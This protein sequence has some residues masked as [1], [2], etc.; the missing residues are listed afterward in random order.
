[1]EE[2]YEN[3][4]IQIGSCLRLFSFFHIQTLYERKKIENSGCPNTYQTR[5]FFNNSKT[6]ADIATRFEQEYV[7]R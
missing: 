7:R 5:Q 1:M 2:I 6:N 4:F 3:M